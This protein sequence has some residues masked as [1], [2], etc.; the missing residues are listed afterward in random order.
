MAEF[1]AKGGAE[2]V[3]ATFNFARSQV[4]RRSCY[5][6]HELDLAIKRWARADHYLGAQV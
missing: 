2:L 5:V 3:R 6:E 4:V 1:A